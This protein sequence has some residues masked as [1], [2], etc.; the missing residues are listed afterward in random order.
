MKELHTGQLYWPTT[1]LN[2]KPYPALEEA[3]TARIAIIGGGMSGVNCAYAFATA[4]LDT[5]LVER[6]EIS[7]GSTSANTGML[8]Y[9]NDTMLCD[10]IVQIGKANA[11]LFYRR[12][13]QAVDE[14]EQAAASLPESV[15]FKRRS[16]FYFASTEQDLPKLR[17]EYEALSEAGLHVEFWT[18]ND[19]VKHFPFRKPGAIV[20]HGD[21]EVNPFQF[22]NSLAD[23]AV[24][25]GA[26][27]H[28]HTDIVRHEPLPDG[29][30]RLHTSSGFTIE[31]DYIVCAVGYEPEELRGKLVKSSMNRS[32]SIATRTIPEPLLKQWHKQWL[33]WETARPYLY[34]R[35]TEDGRIIA[36]GLDERIEQ[37]VHSEAIMKKRGEQLLGKIQA[38]FPDWPLAIEYMWNATFGESQDNLPFI[39]EDPALPGVYYNLGYGGNGTIYS[40]IGARTIL[41]MLQG[42]YTSH[43]F[44][45]IGIRP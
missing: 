44:P 28:E 36:G 10:L 24:K 19:I 37:P 39:G 43:P 38:L 5:L 6:R 17:K 2:T 16:S 9:S 40:M 22:V 34:M 32:Y 30:H 11:Q 23:A 14:L 26:R 25:A 29:R 42:E 35:T 7:E 27:L 15:G 1:R 31:A 12:C 3:A 8:Q 18:S 21:A 20:T 41:G 33:I 13:L 4:G 45:F